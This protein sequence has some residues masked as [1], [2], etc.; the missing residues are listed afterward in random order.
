MNLSGSQAKH[1]IRNQG[2][3]GILSRFQ[4]LEPILGNPKES[5]VGFFSTVIP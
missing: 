4:S 3:Y 2:F 5:V 1:E